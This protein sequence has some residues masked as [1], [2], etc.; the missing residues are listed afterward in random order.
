MS[1]TNPPRIDAH[2]HYWDLSRGDYGWLRAYP[3]R[4]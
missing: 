3:G 2:Q 1:M 4:A